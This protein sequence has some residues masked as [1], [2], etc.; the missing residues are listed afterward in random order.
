MPKRRVFFDNVGAVGII[1]DVPP[2]ELPHNAWTDGRNVRFRDGAVEKMKGRVQVFGDALD[3]PYWLLPLRVRNGFIWFYGSADAIYATDGAS[4]YD[5]TNASATH[6][7][8]VDVN[9]TGGVLGTIAVVNDPSEVPQTWGQDTV[10]AISS[11]TFQTLA[12]WPSEMRCKT[13]RPYKEY[14]VA[15]DIEESSGAG[16]NG[17]L[18]RW[19]HPASPGAVP[20][21][22]DY[23]DAANDAGR[24]ELAQSTD[25][26]IDCQPLR[27][28]NI[29]YRDSSVWTQSFIGGNEI[30]S[31]RRAFDQIGILNRRC[32]RPF[33]GQ[34]FVATKDDVVLHDGHRAQQLL[35]NRLRRWV[36]SRMDPTSYVRAFVAINYRAT[37]MWVCFPE[38]GRTWP[39]I[40]L[41]WNWQ[42]NTWGIHDLPTETT[43]IEFGQAE[44]L[45]QDWS[46]DAA[47]GVFDTDIGAFDDLGYS[48]ARSHMLI[49]DANENKLYRGEETEQFDGQSFRSY[50]ERDVVPLGRPTEGGLMTDIHRYKTVYAIW[51]RLDGT[52]GGTVQIEVGSRNAVDETISWTA[53]RDYH[54][55]QTN[56]VNVLV[57][58][59]IITIRFSSNSN[60]NW[61]LSGYEVEYAIGGER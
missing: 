13:L 46:F 30:F 44:D 7:I 31:F 57:T 45:S 14:L 36:F 2:T 6:A 42:E 49:A 61:R 53:P 25:P 28:T 19:S 26:L 15:M 3:S 5:V 23:E 43:H 21:S 37:E 47:V 41:T 24:V 59:K 33:F 1:K 54:I 32:V 55:G 34:H 27:D 39:N 4:H 56:K 9:W 16:Y 22:W 60:I 11:A 10:T 20:T 35:P 29:I 50:V 17:L 38:S 18:L 58:G 51:P 48:G 8:N 52:L 12:N 40:A